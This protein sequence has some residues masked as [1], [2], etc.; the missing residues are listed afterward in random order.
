M[1]IQT[2]S[3]CGSAWLVG[4]DGKSTEGKGSP[5]GRNAVAFGAGEL[6][7]LVPSNLSCPKCGIKVQTKTT[8]SKGK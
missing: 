8:R 2:I 1:T 6:T 7:E 5:A 3:H 4:L